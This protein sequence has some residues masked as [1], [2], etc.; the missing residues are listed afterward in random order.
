MQDHGIRLQGCEALTYHLQ[1]LPCVSDVNFIQAGSQLQH[2]L[3]VY[4]DV[5]DLPLRSTASHTVFKSR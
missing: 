1:R 2:L 5:T 4:S 3:G